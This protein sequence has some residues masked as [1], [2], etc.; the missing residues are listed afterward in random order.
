MNFPC[1]CT[2][3]GCANSN[4][5][6]EFNPMRVRTH[7]I[8]TM[9]RIEME[10][11]REQ[12]EEEA[13]RSELSGFSGYRQ[14]VSYT[15]YPFEAGFSYPSYGYQP[16]EIDFQQYES[17]QGSFRYP[18]EKTDTFSELLT[19]NRYPESSLQQVQGEDPSQEEP[20]SVDKPQEEPD[21]E[22]FGEIIKKTMV[23]SVT[24]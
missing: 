5:R 12:E 3:D 4:G 9:M 17:F 7:F 15:N 22:N 6:I 20:H 16:Y 23:E 13:R 11:K 24:A 18:E 8:H 14:E 19:P 10:K 1:G 21:V 2:H